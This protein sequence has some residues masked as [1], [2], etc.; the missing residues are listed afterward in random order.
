MS[1]IPV[2]GEVSNSKLAAV[3]DSESVAR[4]AVAEVVA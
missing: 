3:F 1:D 2:T 4:A